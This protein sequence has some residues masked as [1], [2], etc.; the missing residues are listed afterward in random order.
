MNTAL[1]FLYRHKRV[2]IGVIVALV[3]YQV[4]LY[5]RALQLAKAA[6]QGFGE[7]AKG[8]V[9]GVASILTAPARILATAA[10]NVVDYFTSPDEP[11]GTPLSQNN[12]RFDVGDVSISS[13]KEEIPGTV[14]YPWSN[15]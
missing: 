2:V 12:G 3:L 10:A 15:P 4:W 7:G 6:G 13:P 11:T 1:A 9:E 14:R 5:Y 8:T